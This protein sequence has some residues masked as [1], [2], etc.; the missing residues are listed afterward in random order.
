MPEAGA[1][2]P[3]NGEQ[4]LIVQRLEALE[5]RHRYHVIAPAEAD[6]ALHGALVVALARP[7]EPV[8]EEVM[9]LQL[10]EGTGALAGSVAE[11][12][13]HRDGGV[14]VENGPRHAAEKREGRDMPV[15]KRFRRLGRI[16]LDE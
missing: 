10:R 13:R 8:V 7:A 5:A 6:H 9:R 16:G 14:V 4:G 11:D 1:I 12:L 3:I 2:H 15:T